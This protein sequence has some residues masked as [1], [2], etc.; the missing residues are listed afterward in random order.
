[1]RTEDAIIKQA[2]EREQHYL[3]S[4]TAHP[5]SPRRFGDFLLYLEDNLLDVREFAKMRGVN[6]Q[7]CAETYIETVVQS[8]CKNVHSGDVSATKLRQK[9]HAILKVL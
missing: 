8:W 9:L 7:R 4:I 5:D 6:F 2:R 3:D 1:M